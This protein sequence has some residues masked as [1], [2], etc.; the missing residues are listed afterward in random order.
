[1]AASN[2]LAIEA[3]L[4]ARL[5]ERLAA[6]GMPQVYVLTAADLAGVTEEK[7]LVPAVHVVYQGYGVA[8]T[9]HNGRA[10]RVTQTWLAVVATR[11]ARGIKAGEAARAQAGELAGHA[12]AA[13]MGWKPGAAAKPLRLVPGP[14][15]G[16]SAGHQYLPLAF[17]AEIVLQAD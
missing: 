6:S 16:F 7:Q 3:E 12:S 13:L 2:V 15:A 5:Q 9:S 8:E 14:G 11:N 17:E 10:A 4:V 1:M